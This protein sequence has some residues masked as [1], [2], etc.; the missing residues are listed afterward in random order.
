V[1]YPLVEL[2]AAIGL[3]HARPLR[4]RSKLE[5]LYGVVGTSHEVGWLPVAFVRA[6]LGVAAMPFETRR[7]QMFLDWPGKEG[8]ARAITQVT[9]ESE[10]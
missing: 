3:T 7:F 5:Y 8:Q 2:L 1:G 4:L 6:A 9:E 10:S